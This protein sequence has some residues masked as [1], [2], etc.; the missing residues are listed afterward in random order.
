MGNGP[1]DPVIKGE[2]GPGVTAAA[3]AQSAPEQT[4]A[5]A[6]RENVRLMLFP[7]PA[8]DREAPGG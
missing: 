4:A 7:E 6:N 3:I 8:P 2:S 5:L 1:S